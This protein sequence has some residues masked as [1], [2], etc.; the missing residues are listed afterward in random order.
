[1]FDADMMDQLTDS[2][3]DSEYGFSR[4]LRR[5]NGV[6]SKLFGFTILS[7]SYADITVPAAIEPGGEG[8]SPDC[9]AVLCWHKNSVEKC[10]AG[11]GEVLRGRRQ[12]QYY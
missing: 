5:K 8:N 2:L 1:M 9:A 3:T 7:R 12:P 4:A 6:V 10:S 11:A